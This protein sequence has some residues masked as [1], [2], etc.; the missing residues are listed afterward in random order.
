MMAFTKRARV[1]M[2]C[3]WAAR[4]CLEA[5]ETLYLAS[6]GSG[7]AE[8]SVLGRAWRDLHAVNMHGLLNLETNLEMYGRV[9]LGLKPNTPLI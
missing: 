2:D 7:I 5:V 1:R 9:V 6:G 3:A 4:Q 8:S